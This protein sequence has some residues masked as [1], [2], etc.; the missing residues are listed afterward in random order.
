MRTSPNV[1]NTLGSEVLEVTGN[2]SGVY[3]VFRIFRKPT[4]P[5]GLPGHAESGKAE[6]YVRLDQ[7]YSSVM[8][9]HQ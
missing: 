7:G 8:K 4:P 1:K 3:G 2:F 5:L 6:S 9:P